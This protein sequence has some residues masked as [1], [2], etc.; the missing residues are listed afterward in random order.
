MGFVDRVPGGGAGGGSR[1]PGCA[2][3]GATLRSGVKRRGRFFCDGRPCQGLYGLGFGAGT[4]PS[5]PT[6]SAIRG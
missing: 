1:A 4:R 6:L 3:E 5:S 2:P